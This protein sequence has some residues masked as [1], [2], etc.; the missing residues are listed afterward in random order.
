[1]ICKKCAKLSEKQ[2]DAH[3]KKSFYK[4]EKQHVHICFYRHQSLA[5]GPKETAENRVLSLAGELG[6]QKTGAGRSYFTPASTGRPSDPVN[7]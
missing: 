6:S 5:Q 7:G 3:R 2:Q 4:K 1:M